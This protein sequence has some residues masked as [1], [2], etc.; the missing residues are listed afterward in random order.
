MKILSLDISSTTVGYAVLNVIHKQ[1]KL[2]EVGFI[3]PSKQGSLFDRL[4]S[5][6]KEMLA[7]IAKYKPDEICI[8]E[9][10]QFI[11]RKSTA[12]TIIT[13]AVFNRMVGLLAYEQ[14]KKAPHYFP[15][16]TI[17]HGLKKT[18]KAPDKEQMPALVES[19]LKIKIPRRIKKTGRV[20]DELYDQA[21]AISV[22]LYYAYLI[23]GQLKT[24]ES[25]RKKK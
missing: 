1:V 7:V 13:L 12:N 9:I 10:A 19:Y 17:R 16:M 22:G 18:L 23:T 11:P 24:I 21:D 3:K 6:K 8:E 25:M 5:L 4:A 14:L 2:I 15:V 20:A